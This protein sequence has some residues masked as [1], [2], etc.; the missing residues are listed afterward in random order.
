MISVREEQCHSTFYCNQADYDALRHIPNAKGYLSGKKVKNGD[1]LIII[2]NDNSYCYDEE[3][4]EWIKKK[5]I[6]SDGGTGGT[7]TDDYDDL[8]NKP[9]ING[10]V[11]R[12]N[13]TLKDL[14]II[15]YNDTQVKSDITDLK[16]DKQ[17]KTDNTL[18]TTDKT[19]TGAI[20]EVNG[21]Q[22]DT[23]GFSSDYKNI[24]LNRKNGLNPY[25]IPISAII[26][27]AKL[28]ELNDVDSTNI[29]D[30][31]TLVYDGATKKHKYV[32]STGTDELVKM[33]STTDAKHLS[34]LIDKST[35][36]NDNG[37][38]KVK[39]L[40]G[41]EVT[42]AEINHLKGLTM[43]VMDLVNMFANGGVKIINTP[44][45][46]YADLLAYD[47]T[48]LIDGISYLV[49][50]LAD[51]THDNAKT[52]YLIDKTSS[53]PTYFGFAGEHRDFTAN[54]IDLANE[55][56]GKLSTSNIDVDSLWSLLTINDTYKT[57][58]TNNEVFGTHGAKALYDE[59]VSAIGYKANSSDLTTHIND[60]DIHITASERDKWNKV[61]NKIDKTD[62]T[63]I[64]DGSST[65]TQVP[66]AK[67][68]FDNIKKNGLI[69]QGKQ[70]LQNSQ[71]ST[72]FNYCKSNFIVERI[73]GF[74]LEPKDG[75]GYF[76]SASVTIIYCLSSVNYGWILG[77]SDKSGIPMAII[78]M[79]N[80][81][82]KWQ[83]V[84]T[85]SVADVPYTKITN[86]ADKTNIIAGTGHIEYCIKNGICYVNIS[87]I[88]VP[89]SYIPNTTIILSSELPPSEVIQR[90]NSIDGSYTYNGGVVISDKLMAVMTTSGTYIHS[91]LSYPV[92]EK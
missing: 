52:T 82:T 73:C 88:Q 33:D 34:E 51:E 35:I 57:L 24:I 69:W 80:K 75:S 4:K 63:T 81:L 60:T 7:G 49:Y 1:Y 10:V 3:G 59:L 21:N 36:V 62:I 22:L 31:K 26:H 53:T 8:L 44:V 83:R 78:Q 11:L 12:N 71:E 46:T 41:Q 13:K 48:G 87:G 43:N 15:N 86:Y 42:I 50:V 47:K 19:V 68:V 61:D 72:V 5:L 2:D 66:T 25:T 79:A 90:N 39:K 64:I 74:R 20:N 14:G 45:S 76:S 89:V 38:L 9:S 77:I 16:S 65:N 55:V 6:L 91:S 56:T 40:D 27:N 67:S 58:T 18:D 54:P 92:A 37:V 85:T 28:I 70:E 23:V 84:C 17:D 32:S 30:G 29:G